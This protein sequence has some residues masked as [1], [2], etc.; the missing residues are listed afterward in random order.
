ML[1]QSSREFRRPAFD[2]S[3]S[4]GIAPTSSLCGLHTHTRRRAHQQKTARRRLFWLPT[5]ARMM[6]MKRG[7]RQR[8]RRGE[9]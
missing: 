6:G 9:T 7:Q 8:L 2:A 3:F 4:G 5:T 1:L